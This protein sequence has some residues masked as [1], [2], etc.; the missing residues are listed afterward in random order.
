MTVLKLTK[1]F[2]TFHSLPSSF[3][4]TANEFYFPLA[5]SIAE[6]SVNRL[7]PTFLGIN[8]CQGSGK[9]TLTDYL[10]FVFDSYFKLPSV[11]LS[12]D[13][14]YLTL[15][16]RKALAA[17]VHPLFKTRGVPGTHDIELL[18]KTL[19]SLMSFEAT[20]LVPRFNKAIDDRF[21]KEMWTRVDEAPAII[22]LEGW[23][24]G[25][26]SQALEN[27]EH[28]I[29]ALER[30]DDE[31]AIWRQYVN[32]ALTKEYQ[33]LFK[34][35]DRLIFLQAPGFHTVKAW[36]LEQEEKLRQKV[37]SEGRDMNGVMNEQQIERFIQ[38]YQ[39]ITEQSLQVLPLLADDIF[40]LDEKRIIQKAS[41]VGSYNQ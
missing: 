11:G 3:V 1:E 24:V 17:S 15:D 40:Q 22:I 18:E 23:C 39:R 10:L 31:Q 38:H 6:Q 14:F 27:L 12:I 35:L 29:N 41:G 21:E 33:W 4:E 13:D 9:S 25:V 16:E 28:P 30:I 20:T 7:L 8:G 2:A 37:L 32:D 19:N 26:T 34:K 5:K 36:R